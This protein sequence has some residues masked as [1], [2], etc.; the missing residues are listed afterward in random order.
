MMP[1]VAGVVAALTAMTMVSGCAGMDIAGLLNPKNIAA[2]QEILKEAGVSVSFKD[3]KTGETVNIQKKEDVKAIKGQDGKTL[4]EGTDYKFQDGKLLFTNVPQKQKVTIE[5]PDGT[6][7]TIDVEPDNKDQRQQFIPDAAGNFGAIAPGANLDEEF[8]K[9]QEIDKGHRVTVTFGDKITVKKGE[10][11]FLA[12]RNPDRSMIIP[13]MAWAGEED[14]QI[15]F[16]VQVLGPKN[17]PPPP[18]GG[19]APQPDDITN[20]V[21]LLVIKADSKFT[22]YRFKIKKALE[23]FEQ[24]TPDANG[25]IDFSKVTL[26]AAQAV[27]AAD[28][29][30]IAS[31]TKTYNTEAEVRTG[32]QLQE[33][34][35]PP[36]Q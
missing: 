3:P 28:L 7:F 1:K 36:H 24:P 23:R 18:N 16:D 17:P 4:V 8:R 29:E 22:A 11:A 6:K 2:V 34:N 33:D 5:R 21:W 35:P 14:G 32:E 10:I 27:A 13:R 25:F 20:R 19:Q 9:Q 15:A 30:V 12:H 26:P 31:A